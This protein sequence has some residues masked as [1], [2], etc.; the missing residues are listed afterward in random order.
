M[1]GLGGEEGGEG[2]WEMEVRS[3]TYRQ[4][5]DGEDG[6]TMGLGQMAAAAVSLQL[7]TL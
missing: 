2:G 7:C 5:G 4:R 6:R 1:E 3:L